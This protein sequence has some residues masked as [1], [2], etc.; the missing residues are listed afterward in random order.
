MRFAML[1]IVLGFP[2][3]DLYATVR[4]A[5]WTGVP[6]WM[7]ARVGRSCRALLLRNE[8]TAFRANTRR[9]AARRAAAAARALR[10]RAQG[11]RGYAVPPARHSQRRDGARACSRCRS[12]SAAISRRARPRRG[13][14]PPRPQVDRRRVSPSRLIG[15]P[16]GSVFVTSS[17][18]SP[19]APPCPRAGRHRSI[20]APMTI[21]GSDSHCPIVRPSAR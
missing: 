3:I 13:D 10:Q 8:R 20:A 18:R 4:F 5:R 12:I 9:G 16:S 1:L 6:V 15:G 14:C 19:S 21:I 7:L 2:L 17:G 11:A